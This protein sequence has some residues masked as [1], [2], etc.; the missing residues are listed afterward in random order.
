MCTVLCQKVIMITRHLN[1]YC[2][3]YYSLDRVLLIYSSRDL[4]LIAGFDVDGLLKC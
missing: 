4:Y 1:C 2:D 3:S